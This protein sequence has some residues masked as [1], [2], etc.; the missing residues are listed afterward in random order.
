MNSCAW[1]ARAAAAGLLPEMP[2][3]LIERGGSIRIHY[4]SPLNLAQRSAEAVGI[5]NTMQAVT[6]LAQ[7]KP[8][9]MLVFNVV[10]MARELAEINGV[11]ERVMNSEDE[12][13]AASEQQA[14]AAQAQ[15]LL[16]AAPAAASA[17]KDFAQAGV[18]VGQNQA[19]VAGVPQGV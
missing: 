19:P 17:A 4:Q 14:Q 3:A 12:I 2:E 9:V 11:P 6:P 16:A 13:A 7:I 15:Q 8:D 5:L 10:K 18:L 1:A